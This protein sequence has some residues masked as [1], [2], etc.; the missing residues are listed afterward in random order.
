MGFGFG[1]G[2]GTYC[3]PKMYLS[4]KSNLEQK[5]VKMDLLERNFG[6]FRKCL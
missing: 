2:V 6:K 3:L 4:K 1:R 5:F